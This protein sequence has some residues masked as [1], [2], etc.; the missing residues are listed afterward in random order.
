MNSDAADAI[1]S[2]PLAVMYLR[3]ST[4][5][6][7]GRGG[8]AEG[9]SIP[10]QREACLRKAESLG[11]QIVEEFV[12][13]G[14][15]AR[16]A[17]RPEL[18]RMLKYVANHRV[19]TV[20]VHK[21]DR[22]ARNRVD[23]VEINLALRQAGA[24]LVS[25]TENI[26]ETPSGM[27]VHGIMSSIAEFY[28]RNLATESRKGM[29]QKAKGGGTVNAAPFGYLNSRVRTPEGREV[30]TVVLDPERAQWVP[31][32]FE[33]YV[34]GEWTTAMIRDELQKHG[35]MTLPK[36]SRP[37]APIALSH[38]H[39]IL[40]NR[41][42]VGVVTFEGV[43]YPG[44]HEALISEQLFARAQQVREARRQSGEKPR[45]HSHYLKGSL[46][47][48]N[49][50]EPLTFEQSRNRVGTLYDYFYCLGRQRLKN[51]CT[52]KATQAHFLE[53]L[54]EDHW[55][56]ITMSE[57]KLSTVRRLVLEHMDTLLPNQDRAEATAKRELAD[58][59]S[60]SER[61]MQAF[62]ADAISLDHLK[63]EQARISAARA[64]AEALISRNATDRDLVIEKLDYLCALL[65]SP[66]RYYE[67]APESMRRELNQSIFDRIFVFDDE[68]VGAD[69]TEPAQRLLS[70]S[71]EL[72]LARERK[73]VL[74]QPVRTSDLGRTPEVGN[75]SH[76]GEGKGTEEAAQ[77]SSDGRLGAYL[78]A[79]RPRGGFPWER[80]NLGPFKVRG[81]NDHFLVAGTGFEPATSG[82]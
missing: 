8:E 51:G 78:A 27:L 4:K 44:K 60:Q 53:E 19:A 5:D 12:D 35:V 1:V 36:P 52:F 6:Q 28:S 14:E 26:D 24:Q 25:V 56:T 46:Y 20:I 65:G 54:V 63:R 31:W 67:N 41:Y 38:V 64:E 71:L 77:D 49:C 15:S 58:L 10:A 55:S 68:I 57:R 7:A 40:K 75:S 13:A 79:E 16:S 33:H 47:C 50:G 59:A 42:Y 45:V 69:L 18:Q 9:F 74:T 82:L 29:L 61:L 66:M 11:V 30:R 34:T 3:V 2:R 80:K 37:S 72:D 62:Y 21:V 43:E 39:T 22:L 73:R 17:N 23:D 32:I 48:G 81:S 76:R 70:E